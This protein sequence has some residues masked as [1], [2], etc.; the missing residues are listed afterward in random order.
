MSGMDLSE[1]DG[2]WHF[3]FFPSGGTK[4]NEEAFAGRASGCLQSPSSLSIP[5]HVSCQEGP[6]KSWSCFTPGEVQRN[7]LFGSSSV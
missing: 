6:S 2:V 3:F 5:R 4:P 1:S 7:F